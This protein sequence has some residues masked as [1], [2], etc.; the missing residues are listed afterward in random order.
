MDTNHITNAIATALKDLLKFKIVSMVNTG[1]KTQDS[2]ITAILL[3]IL[4][5]I[6]AKNHYDNIT[7]FINTYCYRKKGQPL[8]SSTVK[9]YTDICNSR[10]YL[11]TTWEVTNFDLTS[12][13]IGWYAKVP[14]SNMLDVPQFYDQRDG[15]I[16]MGA[17]RLQTFDEIRVSL[18]LSKHVPIYINNDELVCF[19]K[20]TNNWIFI[21]YETERVF[22]TFISELNKAGDVKNIDDPY[23][24]MIFDINFNTIGTVFND[25]TMDLF[26]SRH[27][28]EIMSA[29]DNFVKINK[30]ASSLGGYGTYN[31][32]LMLYGEPGTGKTMLIKALANYL[33]KDIIMVDMRKIKTRSE[34]ENLFKKY[35]YKYI[36]CLDEFDCVQGAIKQR[37]SEGIDSESYCTKELRLLKERQLEMFKLTTG[38]PS[39]T[40]SPVDQELKNI[41]KKIT[42]LENSLTLDTVLTVLDGINEMRGRIIIATTNY[43]ENIDSALLRAGR[44]DLKIRLSKFNS[45][46]IRDMLLIMYKDKLDKKLINRI[47]ETKFKENTYAPVDIIYY[48]SIMKTANKLINYMKV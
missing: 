21:A 4:T 8:S 46:E 39:S 47:N 1:D 24:R 10:S 44:F 37:T 28:A 30:G 48:A 45:Q 42:E 17:L 26:V 12:N 23:M 32:G 3:A 22:E 29:V 19:Y 36:Y 43:L 9:Y 33:H 27:K 7:Q 15:K 41:E 13:L 6:F 11:Y 5:Y 18:P 34:F 20:H 31:L 14:K 2:L 35:S 40:P 38:V 16:K 25:R